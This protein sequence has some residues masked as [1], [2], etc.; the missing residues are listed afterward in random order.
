MTVGELFESEKLDK[1]FIENNFS[2][3]YW[4]SANKFVQDNWGRDVSALTAKQNNWLSRVLD[5]CVER[6][7]ELKK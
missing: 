1:D 5:D 4:E 7:I 3:P 2:S 6:R